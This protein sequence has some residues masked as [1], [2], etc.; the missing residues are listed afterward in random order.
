[1]LVCVLESISWHAGKW[2][3]SDKWSGPFGPLAGVLKWSGKDIPEWSISP[4]RKKHLPLAAAV[5]CRCHYP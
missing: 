5:P 1:M 3:V 2:S 4:S